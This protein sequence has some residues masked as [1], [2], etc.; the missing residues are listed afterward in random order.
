MTTTQEARTESQPE[1][2]NTADRKHA[3]RWSSRA[4]LTRMFVA[5]AVL[6]VLVMGVVN[7]LGAQTI[8]DETVESHLGSVA[9]DR[10]TAVDAELGR[11]MAE[12]SVAAQDSGIALATREFTETFI[13]LAGSSSTLNS[14]QEREL[15]DFYASI[16]V[17]GLG[18]GDADVV[19][20]SDLVPQGASARYV[21]YYYIADNPFD[22]DQRKDLV[23]AE[24]GSSYSTT[25]SVYH[26]TMTDRS[27]LMG[28]DDLLL[29]SRDAGDS[30][31]Y[32][33]K[34]R[35][36]FGTSLLA[37]P[38][39]GTSLAEAVT[40]QLASVP[41]GEAIVIDFEPYLPNGGVPTMFVAAAITDQAG[42]VGS[43]VAALPR[44]LLDDVTSFGGSLSVVLGGERGEVYLVGSDVLMRTMSRFWPEN[45][46]VYL[47]SLTEAG[48]PAE[49]GEQITRYDST[50]LAQPVDTE[51]VATALDGE[52]FLDQDT[53][54]LGDKTF[55]Y[56]EPLQVAG[57]DWVVVAETSASNAR[58]FLMDYLWS[59]FILGLITIPVVAVAAYL[60][61]RRLTRPVVPLT[62]ASVAIA[63][64]DVSVQV[65]DLG[66]NEYGDLGNRINLVSAAIRQKDSE[67]DQR[68]TE[69]L[70]VLLA[71]LPPRLVEPARAAIEDGTI[72]TSADFGD[73]ADTCTV[74]AVSVS[75]YFDLAVSD[76][77]TVVDISSLF[78]RSVEGLAADSNIE[79]VRSTPDEYIFTAGLRTEGFATHD[80]VRFVSR[81]QELLK[82]LQ[83]DTSHTGE[84]RVGLSV[85]RVASG[86]LR[87]TELSFGIWGP[88]VTRALS[89]VASADAYQV[90]IDQSVADEI[91]ESWSIEP[92][93]VTEQYGEKLGIYSLQLAD[94]Q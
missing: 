94:E 90:L 60:L 35:T 70:Q 27:D 71:A 68:N 58:S 23:N 73:L 7:L 76:M 18:S 92:V 17:T 87:G 39:S 6:A 36:D 8:F 79:R 63:A 30:V 69:I 15:E 13:G 45:P 3:R 12:L 4:V 51:A 53:N 61:A 9:S 16:E 40:S 59:L 80:A 48:Y 85:G 14:G 86:V 20:S 83:H 43:L 22:A 38:Y 65:P 26:Q 77:E 28:V 46:S 34:K 2:S 67:R 57:L 66:R 33:V 31:V 37:G 25:H 74:I 19:S 52:A 42:V 5:V 29:I 88:P 75:G 10:A 78:A 1:S 89:L 32:S 50:V 91:G 72:T 82:E 62:E 49:V 81:L 84:Y 54:Y 44:D 64:G 47:E 41:V 93:D 11:A 56:A 21:Q 55:T 24:D